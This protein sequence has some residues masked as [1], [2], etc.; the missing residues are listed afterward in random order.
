MATKIKGICKGFKY[1]TQIF[2][3]KER[4]MDI[5]YPTDVKHVAHIGWDGPTGSGPS[6]MNEFKTAPDFSTSIGSLSERRDPNA[7]TITSSR[8]VQDFGATSGSQPKPNLYQGISSAGVSHVHK[9][10]KR[11]KTKSTSSPKASSAATRQSR[12]ARTKATYCEREAAP[13]A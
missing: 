8:S 13:I 1:I 4:E 5:G 9:K 12:A 2:V 11:K 7:S 6:W 10:A 3:V